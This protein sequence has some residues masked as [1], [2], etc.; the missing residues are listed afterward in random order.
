MAINKKY[1]QGAD[2]IG[3]IAGKALDL[4]ADRMEENTEAVRAAVKKQVSINEGIFDCLDEYDKRLEILEFGYRPV[5][6]SMVYKFSPKIKACIAG[7]LC[8]IPC[9]ELGRDYLAHIFSFLGVSPAQNENSS[10]LNDTAAEVTAG[11]LFKLSAIDDSEEAQSAISEALDSLA[12]SKKSLMR[13]ASQ[14]SNV[15][16]T[17]KDSFYDYMI[18][19]LE[20]PEFF[21]RP[22]ISPRKMPRKIQGVLIGRTGSG[23]TT[24]IQS[25]FAQEKM[26]MTTSKIQNKIFTLYSDD[27]NKFNLFDTTGL[28]LGDQRELFSA[29]RKLVAEKSVN[30]LVYCVNLSLLRF[31]EIEGE[32]I[33]SIRNEIP[34]LSIYVVLTN[35]CQ[36]DSDE[37]QQMTKHIQGLT[38][39]VPVIPVLAKDKSV[40][41][42]TFEAYGIREFVKEIAYE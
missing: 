12:V 33:R 13:I 39:Y 38:N 31:E 24:L 34:S 21:I 15:Q 1:K 32:L 11:F 40:G 30:T 22:I 14:I 10:L 2:D 25:I 42:F 5:D 20:D 17:L 7:M 19:E 4:F 41:D 28:K 18:K 26:K 29:L 23:K 16:E 37:V 6:M 9:G 8:G 3:K 27:S 36:P 35:C